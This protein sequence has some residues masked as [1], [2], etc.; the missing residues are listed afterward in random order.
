M[1]TQSKTFLFQ[2]I[3]FCKT[4]L[5]QTIQFRIS[6]VFVHQQL[7]VKT[8]LFQPIQFSLSLQFSSN[9]PIDRTLSGAASPSQSG[10]GN[11]GNEGVLR[12][13]QSYKFTWTSPLD[14]LVSYIRTL[15]EGGHSCTVGVF[16]SPSR[17][18]NV[19]QGTYIYIYIYIYILCWAKSVSSCRSSTYI[20][21]R[22]KLQWSRY[23]KFKILN[24]K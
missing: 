4:V 2:A 24:S 6:T 17:L 13:P 5:N 7:N 18:S 12:I 1:S 22:R 23:L 11:D 14:Y 16:Y 3:R 15:F 21:W 9:W 19:E 8:V 20:K 10:L